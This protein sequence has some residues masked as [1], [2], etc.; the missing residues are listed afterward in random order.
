MVKTEM[1]EKG[2]KD[3]IGKLEMKLKSSGRLSY[4]M[5]T[6]FHGAL[7]EMLPKGYADELHHSELHPYSQYLVFKKQE[8]YWVVCCFNEKAV[9]NII[10]DA[11][12]KTERLEIKKENI[13]IEIQQKDYTE[14]RH[15]ELMKHF[16]EKTGKRYLRVH[17]LT[18]TAFK[19]QGKYI[20]YPD[21]R[22]IYQSLMN[23][24]DAAVREESMTDEET[25]EQLCENSQIVRYDLKS[26]P[27]V[28][29]KVKIPGYVG[30]ITIKI[31]GTQTMVNFAN[32]LFEFGEY[33][34]IGIKTALGMGAVRIT[35][36]EGDRSDRK[37][38]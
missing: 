6:L 8:Y 2:E 9:R 35:K 34:G 30:K 25:L 15:S 27:F 14:I 4:Q 23:K 29:E 19:Q 10:W 28:M 26:V 16:Y 13:E 31:S 17:F 36:E 22:C 5:G 1:K 33:S 21:I 3:M 38:D 18:P 32:L 12:Q 7:M 11:L 24:Y 37:T 20:F